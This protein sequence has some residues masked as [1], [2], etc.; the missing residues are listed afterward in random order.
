MRS[1]DGRGLAKRAR[2]S[3]L[4]PQ[5]HI[6]KTSHAFDP[7]TQKAEEDQKFKASLGYAKLAHAVLLSCC[8]EGQAGIQLLVLRSV[9]RMDSGEVERAS[10][11]LC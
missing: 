9:D 3:G 10:R 11:A 5:H 4:S 6:N 1:S 7:S 2:S 8:R